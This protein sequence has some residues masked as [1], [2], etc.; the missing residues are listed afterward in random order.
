MTPDVGQKIVDSLGK[1]DLNLDGNIINLAVVGSS[2]FYDFEIFEELIEKWVD[3]NGYP[4]MI[5][6]GGASGVDYMAERWS[7]N[8]SIPIAIFSEEW[9]D[10]NRTLRDRGRSEAP[11]SL[12]EK[13]LNSATDILAIPSLTSKWTRIVIKMAFEK[14]I[15]TTIYEIDE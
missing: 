10:P 12:T 1:K 7:D 15:P 3:K 4:D 9:D 13:I 8:N 14:N 11:N 5:I 2:R 6:V